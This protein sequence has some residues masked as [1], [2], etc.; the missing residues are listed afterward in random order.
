VNQGS[1]V[2]VRNV[3]EDATE[4]EAERRRSSRRRQ[5]WLAAAMVTAALLSGLNALVQV[6]KVTLDYSCRRGWLS[7]ECRAPTDRQ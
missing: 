6:G 2:D 7:V 3:G 4:T 1:E 5:Q